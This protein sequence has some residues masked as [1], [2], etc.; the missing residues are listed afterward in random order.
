MKRAIFTSLLA[1]AACVT[2]ALAEDFVGKVEVGGIIAD[3]KGNKTKFNEYRDIGSGVKGSFLL[4]WAD[5]NGYYVNLTGENFGVSDSE[6][7]KDQEFLFNVGLR[8]SFKYSIFYKETPHNLSLDARSAFNT[9]TIGTTAL[10]S[11]LATGD[12]TSAANLAQYYNKPT[13]DYTMDRKDYGAELE[14]SFKS[15]YFFNARVA[16]NETK[17]L[18]P[19]GASL[20]GIKELPAPIDYTTDNVYLTTGYRSNKLIATLDG[21]I[22]DFKNSN[23]SFT[24]GF[25]AAPGATARTYLAPDSMNY[26]VGGNVMYRLPFWNTT[27]AARGSH[28]ISENT[29]ALNEEAGVTTTAGVSNFQG[30]ITYTTASAAITSTPIKPLDVKLYLNVLDK[31]NESTEPFR[32]SV[33]AFNVATGTTEKFSYNKLNGGFDLGFK[34]PAKTKLTAGYEYLRINRTSAAPDLANTSS[35][36]VRNDA[37]QTTDHILYA[38]VK[39]TLLHWLTAKARYERMYRSSEFQGDVF[40]SLGDNRQIKAFWRPVDTA[41]KTQDTVK[42]GLDFEPLDA[43]SIGVEYS[44][45]YNNYTESVLGMQNDTRHELYLDANYKIAMVKVNPFVELE[46]VDNFSKHRRYQTAGAASPF[47]GVNDGTNYN[48]TSTREDVNYALGLN[49][50]VEIIKEKL[51]LSSGYRYE[52]ADGSEDFSSTFVPATP[53]TN[54]VSLDDYTKQTLSAKLKYNITKNLNIGLCYLF[55]DLKY[56]DDHYNGYTYLTTATTGSGT[57]LTGAYNSPDYQAH[58]GYVTV[59]YKF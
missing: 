30:K 48:W 31:R 44:Y 55:E 24:Y 13:F 1:V 22:S 33:G 28:S 12:N 23:S 25:N 37:P 39:N 58:A 50:D 47:S 32:Y 36:G 29:I 45:K 46:M 11:T 57:Q 42:L 15:P 49:T 54:N 20:S 18:L 3:V 2:P 4:D 38:Q 59:A 27:I 41:D 6:V 56:S 53:I 17:G 26:K 16:H 34:L 5:N 21:T 19:M 40:A 7:R 14:F 35:W 10:T 8:E 52:K 43:L 9:S 51:I